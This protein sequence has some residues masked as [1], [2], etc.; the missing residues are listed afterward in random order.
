M[1]DP[2]SLTLGILTMLGASEAIAKGL[3][4]LVNLRHASIIVLA[5]SNEVTDLRV[6]LR[7]TYDLLQLAH[8]HL[9]HEIPSSLTTILERLEGSLLDI[10]RFLASI[11]REEGEGS[12]KFDRSKYARSGK[13]TRNM[14]ESI[15]D[16]RQTLDSALDRFIL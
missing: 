5:L 11:I 9:D 6:L 2:V 13:V 1:M 8:S 10:Q 15:R 3:K 4:I 14:M 12:V 7:K 16:R